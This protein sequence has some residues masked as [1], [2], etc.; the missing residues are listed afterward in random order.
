MR[1][2]QLVHSTTGTLKQN[3]VLLMSMLSE[4]QQF[5]IEN[6]FAMFD[7][8]GN[9]KIEP[10]E[11]ISVMQIIGLHPGREQVGLRHLH[12]RT[13]TARVPALRSPAGVPHTLTELQLTACLSRHIHSR[14]SKR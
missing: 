12:Q 3:S 9:G 2:E 13:H 11:I 5:E 1:R 6:A 4:G 14:R 8:N 7:K 10:H